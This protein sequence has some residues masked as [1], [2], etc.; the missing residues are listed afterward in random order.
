MNLQEVST[1][2]KKVLEEST[3]RQIADANS[4][5]I[6]TGVMDSYAM[7]MLIAFVEEKFGVTLDMEAL[8]F[9]AFISINSFSELVLNH[10]SK[11]PV[12]HQ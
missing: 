11:S 8:D 12:A 7:L 4:D 5:L 9:D 2:I 3:G 10:Q 1:N 6:A